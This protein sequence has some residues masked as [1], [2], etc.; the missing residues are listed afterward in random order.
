MKNY[1]KVVVTAKNV[2]VF[3]FEDEDETSAQV[4]L[5]AA[6]AVA[7]G[8]GGKIVVWSPTKLVPTNVP[9]VGRVYDN[10]GRVASGIL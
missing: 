6:G 5:L 10:F 8:C 9:V 1:L 7:H 4:A 3:P 2:S